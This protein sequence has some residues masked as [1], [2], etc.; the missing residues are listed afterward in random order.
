ME[1]FN[2]DINPSDQFVEAYAD[3]AFFARNPPIAEAF[4]RAE[5]SAAPLWP[6]CCW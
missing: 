1:I 2:R 6:A 4:G 3:L 5:R